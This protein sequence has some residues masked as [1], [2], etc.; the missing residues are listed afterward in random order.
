[1]EQEVFEFVFA[2]MENPGPYLTGANGTA[3]GS[4]PTG[5]NYPAFY[6]PFPN[7]RRIRDPAHRLALFRHHRPGHE[8]PA[9]TPELR[10][11]LKLPVLLGGYRARVKDAAT[12]YEVEMEYLLGAVR[13][14][15]R[16]KG[17][18]V[19]CHIDSP[20]E[21]L[22]YRRL[23]GAGG[24]LEGDRGSDCH[25]APD[26][27]HPARPEIIAALE[28]AGLDRINLSLHALDPR[29][30]R[31]LPGLTGSIST[32]SR[33]PHGRLPEQDRPFDRPGLYPGDQ[34][35]RDPE[36]D[37]VCAGDRGRQ[38]VPAPRHPEVRALPVRQVA[39][40]SESPELV[41][42][43]QPEP[44]AMGEGVRDPET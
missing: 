27:W 31:C 19:E 18:G 3:T 6:D 42:V 8:P 40:R 36:T 17:P 33:S 32:S 25:L 9:G 20:G 41:A 22:M 26:Q 11:Q 38:T 16:F 39:Q 30:Q 24:G 43:L 13:E 4:C 28:S 12:S 23:P 14:I 21:P 29:S 34:R 15:A 2:R 44:P 35:C 7:H 1:M 37:P 5:I 10:L